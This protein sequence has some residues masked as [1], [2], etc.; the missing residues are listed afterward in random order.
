MLGV[1]G[2]CFCHIAVV[3]TAIVDSFPYTEEFGKTL[4]EW[5]QLGWAE[6]TMS[7]NCLS[8]LLIQLGFD[9]PS[10]FTSSGK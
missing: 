10:I 8:T 5:A 2:S 1:Q 3:R 7:M 9:C 6:S 4:C